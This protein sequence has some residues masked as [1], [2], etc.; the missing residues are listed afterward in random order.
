WT[1]GISWTYTTPSAPVAGCMLDYA[2]NYDADATLSDG[3]C[4]F[5]SYSPP[6]TLDLRLHLDPTNSSSYSGSGTNV[7]DLSGF[8]NNGTIAAAGPVW[9]ADFT[10]FTYDGACTGSG[11]YICDEVNIT[12]STTLRPGEPYEDLAV[13]LNQGSTTQYLTAPETTAGNTLGAVETSFTIQAWVKP[14]DCENPTGAPTI[15][16]KVYS[17]KIGCDDGTWHYVLG[18]GTAWYTGWVDT[19]VPADNNVWHHVALTRAS[20]STGVKFFLNGVQSYSVSSYEGDLGNNNNQSLYVGSRSGQYATSDAWHG[21]IDDVRIYTSDRSS[22]VA[23]DMNK[24]PNV[25]DAA[26]NAY[27]DFNLERHN[28]TVTSVPNM[29]TGSGA[30]SASLTSVTG[31]PKVVRTWDV[32]TVGSDTVLTFER[33]VLTA[34]GGWRV[35]TGV[36]SADVLIVGGGGGGGYNTGGGGGG[37]GVGF[38]NSTELPSGSFVTVVVGQGGMGATTSGGNGT[39]GQPSQLRTSIVGGGGGGAGWLSGGGNG[40]DAPTGSPVFAQ[41]GSGGGGAHT[42]GQGGTGATNGGDAALNAGGGGGGAG[43]NGSSVTVNQAGADGGAGLASSI[44]GSNLTYGSGAGGGGWT[45]A[46]SGGSGAG[47]GGR[48]YAATDGTTNRGG[49]GGG[50]GNSGDELGGNGGSGVVIVRYA[51]VDH[52]DW[53]VATWINASSLQGSTIIGTYNDDGQ[54]SDIG[55]ALRI[56]AANGNLYSTVG[57]STNNSAAWTSDASINTDRWYHVVMVADVG[58]TLRLY[59]DGVNVANGSLSGGG[60]I[61]DVSNNVFLGSYNGGEEDQPFDGQIGSVMVFADA[62]NATNINQLYTSGKG[63]Y[64]NTTNLSYAQSSS[65]LIL[66]QTYSFPLTVA[67][68]EV[69]TSYSLSG[70]LP[71]G[72]NFESSNGT[73]WGTP[74]TTMTSTTYTVVANNSAGSYSTS[75]SLTSQHVAPYDLVYSPENMTLTKGTAMTTNT[76]S[77]SGGTITSW[78]ISPSLPSGLA[79]STSTGAISGTPTVL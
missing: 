17:F 53:S 24:Y 36:S 13:E 75:I 11:P 32:S 45:G 7:A 38:F 22:S 5:A 25:N 51:S 69:T 78:E 48:N 60:N 44:S 29:A 23:D 14:T 66:G 54:P 71:S 20:S 15:L 70:T 12:D 76:P 40:V 52:N 68:G 4:L 55:W 67:N 28:D 46:G 64:S 30:S 56:R 47:N 33:T 42:N 57:T 39:N 16:S 3:S 37:G 62:L 49:G 77:V 65:T 31:S 10:R 43:A 35:P 59:L 58:N 27:F 1:A 19:G 72:M 18:N 50:G 26:L 8:N 61:R 9:D 21:L 79:F 74:T 63:V 73:I 6:S 34:Q 2:D 41:N